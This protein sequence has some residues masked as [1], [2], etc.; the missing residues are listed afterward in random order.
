MP[1]QPTWLSASPPTSLQRRRSLLN[2]INSSFKSLFRFCTHQALANLPRGFFQPFSHHISPSFTLRS[3]SSKDWS[4]VRLRDAV[5][6]INPDRPAAAKSWANSKKRF[7]HPSRNKACLAI[8]CRST[9]QEAAN[10]AARRKQ[11]SSTPRRH[12]PTGLFLL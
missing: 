12:P 8:L 11:A 2:M 10:R 9:Y 6:S 7:P 3:V 1:S 4:E 5:L